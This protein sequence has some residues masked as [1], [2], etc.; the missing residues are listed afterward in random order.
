MRGADKWQEVFHYHKTAETQTPIFHIDMFMTLA[1]PDA[2]GREQILVGDP[3]MAAEI[4]DT[5]LHPLAL[6]TQFDAIA[7]DLTKHGFSV[8]RNLAENLGGL[9]CLTNVLKRG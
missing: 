2:D 4:L 3:L 9:H 8:I 6:A 7:E 5:P 1:G